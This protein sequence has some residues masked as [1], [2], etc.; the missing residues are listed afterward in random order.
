[1]AKI[2]PQPPPKNRNIPPPRFCSRREPTTPK[3]PRATDGEKKR[4]NLHE[5]LQS[6]EQRRRLTDLGKGQ[7][8]D[9][10]L[11]DLIFEHGCILLSVVGF[12]CDKDS[13]KYPGSTFPKKNAKY[14]TQSQKKTKG[15]ERI[16]LVWRSRCGE[17]E[18]CRLCVVAIQN[19]ALRIRAFS[20]TQ[21]GQ[22]PVIIILVFIVFA[23]F[24]INQRL[25][26]NPRTS[27]AIHY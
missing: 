6:H 3:P 15:V 10:I 5:Q 1:V 20:D 13:V 27:N 12:A 18:I 9:E 19:F 25:K 16:L 8:S 4:L 14:R 22:F 26:K 24:S 7:F 2:W 11:T 21:E 17:T 23:K